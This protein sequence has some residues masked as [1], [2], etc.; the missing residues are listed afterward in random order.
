VHLGSLG[1]K[2]S[3]KMMMKLMQELIKENGR[4]VVKRDKC[5]SGS[6]NSNGKTSGVNPIKET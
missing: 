3:H 6:I 2:A 5:G 1:V 4:K